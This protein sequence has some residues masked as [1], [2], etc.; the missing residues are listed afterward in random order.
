MNL[1]VNHKDTSKYIPLRDLLR[2]NHD[3]KVQ[4]YL[5][6]LKAEDAEE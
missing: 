3:E 2:Q 4:N 5:E 6:K 1:S